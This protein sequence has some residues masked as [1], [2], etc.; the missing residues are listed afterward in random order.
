MIID[1][2]H[3]LKLIKGLQNFQK[4]GANISIVPSEKD[5]EKHPSGSVDPILSDILAQSFV[6][7]QKIL[8]EIYRDVSLRPHETKANKYSPLSFS[9]ELTVSKNK[10]Y[11]FEF[12]HL[13]EKHLCFLHP[14]AI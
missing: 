11:F 3:L 10:P 6:R 4:T 7:E 13:C 8:R 5:N 1:E 9:L 14:A 12:F 2:S